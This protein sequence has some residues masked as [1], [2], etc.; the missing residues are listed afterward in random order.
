MPF[1]C[2]FLSFMAHYTYFLSK[3][4][5]FNFV[6][7]CFLIS[8]RFFKQRIRRSNS[9]DVEKILLL[10]ETF[11]RTLQ[12]YLN[13]S[14][15]EDRDTSERI[16][17]LYRVCP[18][19]FN[20]LVF[21]SSP[22]NSDD[23]DEVEADISIHNIH[24]Y[25]SILLWKPFTRKTAESR[26]GFGMNLSKLNVMHPFLSQLRTAFASDYNESSATEL[27]H[28]AIKWYFKVTFSYK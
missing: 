20:S 4:N 27:G 23:F 3:Y 1:S 26:F 22:S 13:G 8:N 14:Y 15:P 19:V 7:I 24:L 2:A 12:L 25:H 18:S 5:I 28:Y 10:E 9:R 17:L 21:H 16:Q 11:R 6:E